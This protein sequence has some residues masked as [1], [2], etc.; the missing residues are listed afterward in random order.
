MSIKSV[1]RMLA[2]RLVYPHSY[3]HEAYMHYLRDVCHVTIG[4]HCKMWYPNEL[5]IDTTRPHMIKIGDYVKF[6][7]NITI[8]CHDYSRSVYCNMPGYSNV[9]E[10]RETIIEDNVFIGMNATILMG[11][12]IGKN[13]IVGAGAVVSGVFPDNV[14]IAGNP[15]KV[16]CTID[17]YYNKRKENEIKSAKLYV[18]RWR[19]MYKRNPTIKEMTNAFAWLYLPHT[20]RSIEEYPELFDLSAV[21]KE[22]EMQNFLD[23]E[24]IYNSFEDF[25]KDCE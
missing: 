8:L 3:S 17:E 14:V 24:P 18:T 21:D 7:R 2:R 6:T 22:I 25:L 23:S 5:H 11:A 19:E 16:I 13:S 10:A 4:E 12:H 1:V 9:G 15:A 20:I